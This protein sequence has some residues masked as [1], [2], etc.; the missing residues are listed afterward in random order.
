MPTF[1]VGE[2]VNLKSSPDTPMTIEIVDGQIAHCKWLNKN[3]GPERSPF[4]FAV[5]E[6]FVSL[7]E[8]V[9]KLYE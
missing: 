2:I 5:L 7:Q 6:K 3:G 8:R 1:Q 4:S 9:G